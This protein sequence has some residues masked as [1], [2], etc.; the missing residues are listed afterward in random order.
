MQK[1]LWEKEKPT[2]E[3]IRPLRKRCG[4]LF[5]EL[6]YIY[7]EEPCLF[8]VTIALYEV[9]ETKWEAIVKLPTRDINEEYYAFKIPGGHAGLS[10]KNFVETFKS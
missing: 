4:S 6:I 10:K 2:R 1:K 7:S 8:L 3:E 9:K 5:E